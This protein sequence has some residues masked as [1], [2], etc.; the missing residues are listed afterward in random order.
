MRWLFKRKETYIDGFYFSKLPKVD[1]NDN[2][3]RR[4]T[5]SEAELDLFKNTVKQYIDRKENKLID[6]EWQQRILAS[7][8]F[9]IAS[10]T[11][12]RSCEQK[13]LLWSDI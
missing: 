11:G 3:I 6:K 10:V 12:L 9:L 1:K 8:Y 4:S 2:N 13:Q 7:Y 5:F